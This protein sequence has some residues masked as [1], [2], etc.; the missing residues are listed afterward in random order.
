[1]QVD[2]GACPARG[3]IVISEYLGANIPSAVGRKGRLARLLK[4]SGIDIA[5]MT[6]HV[7]RSVANQWCTA[8]SSAA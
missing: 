1:V 3:P 5:V 7:A 8:A 2:A 4:S 6:L